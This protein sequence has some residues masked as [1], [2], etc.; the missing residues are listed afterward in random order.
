MMTFKCIS[1]GSKPCLNKSCDRTARSTAS[2]LCQSYL[3][4][5][6]DR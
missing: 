3:K 4:A 5:K 1:D 2:D 6:L